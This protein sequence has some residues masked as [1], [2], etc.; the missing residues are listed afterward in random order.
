[1]AGAK[2]ALKTSASSSPP[3]TGFTDSDGNSVPLST[4]IPERSTPK[5]SVSFHADT[6]PRSED[7][8]YSDDN[9]DDR[10]SI[11]RIERRSQGQQEYAFLVLDY[12]MIII[13]LASVHITLDILVHKQYHQELIFREICN[14]G[15]MSFFV[16]FVLHSVLHP[17]HG[18]I[19]MQ[20]LL[21]FAS[22]LGGTYL[23]K[24]CEM[25]Y[26]AVMKQAPALGTLL[27][28]LAVELEYYWSVLAVVVVALITWLIKV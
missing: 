15:L 7:P 3:I 14:R 26:Y 11:R 19:P 6:K 12:L 20:M 18:T 5:K 2:P 13:P 16:L 10:P 17:T 4:L 8:D 21:L 25:D 28:W 22:I 23:I 9:A 1:M 24:V 27:S